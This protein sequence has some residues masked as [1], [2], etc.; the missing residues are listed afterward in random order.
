MLAP[1]LKTSNRVGQTT[2][3]STVNALPD[4]KQFD[5]TNELATSHCQGKKER[6]QGHKIYSVFRLIEFVKLISLKILF[7]V[8]FVPKLQPITAKLMVV[9]LVAPAPKA[10]SPPLIGVSGTFSSSF[11]SSL[12][13]D[14][15]VVS[16][17]SQPVL[18]RNDQCRWIGAKMAIQADEVQSQ[19]QGIVSA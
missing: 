9:D 5:Q 4:L 11:P 10:E 14:W 2:F 12:V 7:V 1:S 8:T 15:C 19:I 3:F 16:H 6:N 18:R 13:S 17:T